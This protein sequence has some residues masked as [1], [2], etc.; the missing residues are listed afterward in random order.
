MNKYYEGQSLEDL[1]VGA[2]LNDE[3]FLNELSNMVNAANMTAQ[4]ATDYLASMGVDAEVETV[5]TSE[6]VKKKVN[7]LE[8]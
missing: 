6:P 7:D 1:E 5:T 4:E 8:P 3:G 2:N